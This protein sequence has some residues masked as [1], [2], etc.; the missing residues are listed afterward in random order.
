[1]KF[2]IQAERFRKAVEPAADIATKN[3]V[4]DGPNF[5]FRYADLVTI[6][7]TEA[8]LSITAFG[9]TASI[10]SRLVAA[11]GYHP[12][13]PG[14]A[15]V[16][17]NEI[18]TSLGSF[19]PLDNLLITMDGDYM[20]ITL[21]SDPEV[22]IRFLT[23]KDSVQCPKLPATF[24][25]STQV[26]QEYFVRGL[27]KVAFAMAFENK[28]YQYMC[29]LFESWP[30]RIRFSAGSGARFAVA[31]YEK[32]QGKIAS[33]TT[34]LIIPKVH[35][36]N[37]MH[38]FKYF[39][40][41]KFTIGL[42]DKRPR[43]HI[44]EQLVLT[45]ANITVAVYNLEF[46]KTYPNM[47]WVLDYP[48]PYR[49]CTRIA[50]WKKAMQ[51][52]GS[53]YHR[54]PQAIHDTQIT[55]NLVEGYF[56]IQP[57]SPLQ[58]NTK[59]HFALGPSIIPVEINRDH[60]PWFRCNSEYLME[61]VKKGDKNDIVVVNMEDQTHFERISKDCRKQRRPI[62]IKYPNKIGN[63]ICEKFYIFFTVSTLG[64]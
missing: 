25:Q 14:N 30:H 24:V 41:S 13:Q 12:Q 15:T 52:V 19:C 32:T 33:H 61:W 20:Q 48:Y 42:A 3:I 16:S 29:V 46:L 43:K 31:E 59:V 21:L 40:T 17:A 58:L 49:I 37:L 34:R 56:V 60:K 55:A 44:V 36:S 45:N 50:E 23:S 18:Y 57:Q 53:T 64:E 38:I 1:M 47:N 26:D 7:A 4:R 63:G 11:D 28:M 27:Q 62:L 5:E 8:T 6:E 51:A 2:T 22:Y 9:G 10:I 39:G 54:H 35:I